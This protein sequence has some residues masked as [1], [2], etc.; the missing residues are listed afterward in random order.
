[1]AEVGF[2]TDDR[3]LPSTAEVYEAGAAE[4]VFRLRRALA[5][6][7]RARIAFAGGSTPRGLYRRLLVS[8]WLEAVDWSRV[9]AFWGDERCVPPSH[10]ESNYLMVWETLL[11]NLPG[12]LAKVNR[13]PVELGAEEA[14]ARYADV[15]GEAPLDLIIL[16]MG[17]DGHTLS[18]FP[19]TPEPASGAK[20]IATSAP[21]EPRSRVS[22]TLETASMAGAALMLVTGA[23]KA[24]MVGQVLEQRRCGAPLL[25]AARVKPAE[26]AMVWMMDPAAAALEADAGSE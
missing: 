15:L 12:P 4:V 11:A 8:P 19:H 1:M 26:G 3:T 25:P 20:V 5:V 18:I 10:P 9:E 6:K 24:K 22:I 23:G 14:A 16:G 21:V 13:I 7:E 17:A 2:E